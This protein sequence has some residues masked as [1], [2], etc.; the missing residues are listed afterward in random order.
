[1]FEPPL[2]DLHMLRL[3]IP[4]HPFALSLSLSH[5]LIFSLA[6]THTRT[7]AYPP[8]CI[9]RTR[10]THSPHTLT[11][12]QSTPCC[13]AKDIVTLL[14]EAARDERIQVSRSTRQEANRA[15]P[16]GRNSKCPK[17]PSKQ[18]THP[19]KNTGQTAPTRLVSSRLANGEMENQ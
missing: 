2:H 11:D 16:V 7:A 4:Q 5:S 15:A 19:P 13:R 3:R 14:T 6:H 12:A 1:M 9:G 8:D 10:T 17:T 18:C